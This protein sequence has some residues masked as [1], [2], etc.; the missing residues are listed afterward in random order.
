MGRR[1]CTHRVEH[2]REEETEGMGERG[3][4]AV[5]SDFRGREIARLGRGA[6]PPSLP[7]RRERGGG[8]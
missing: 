1:N 2:F 8:D 3:L 7:S 4:L 6:R 5:G